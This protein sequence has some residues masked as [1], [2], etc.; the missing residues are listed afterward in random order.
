MGKPENKSI[1]RRQL[2]KSGAA[3]AAA[4]VAL[5][6][7]PAVASKNSKITG[8]NDDIL[9]GVIGTGNMGRANMMGFANEENVRV[10][11]VCD[12]Y[13]KNMDRALEKLEEE[14]KPAPQTFSD[15]RKLLEMKELDI[16]VVATPDHWHPLMS[17]M[18]C[19]AGKDVYVEKPISV[20]VSEG[21]KMV[22]VGRETKRV[23]GVGTQQRSGEHFQRAVEIVQSG[24]LGRITRVE[25]WNYG[26]EYPEG[27]GNPP[28]SEPPE[29]LDWDMWLGP[30]P[31]RP[32]NK[33]RF[34]VD[35]KGYWSTFRWFWDYAGGWMT[36]WGTH[37]IDVVQWA[38]ETN[39]PEYVSASGGK[40]AILDNRE[41]PDTMLA[42]FEYPDFICTY[43][44]R[45]C[46]R[47][48]KD[49]RGYGILFH[50]TD[51]SLFVDRQGY[52]LAPEMERLGD[53]SHAKTLPVSS[54]ESDQHQPHIKA[55][56]ECVKSRKRF[57]SDIEI[58]HYA[59]ATPH[60]ANI[61][62]RLGRRL[63]YDLENERFIGDDQANSMLAREYRAPWK[64]V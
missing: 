12:C 30:A 36:D 41:T 17:V 26:N 32:F 18:A 16:V 35:V 23:V 48:T 44:Y 13:K 43:E 45:G 25:T 51:A 64:L 21:R 56:I 54:G 49:G 42:I 3:L 38:M 61:S 4:A 58:G 22:E 2:L 50:G 5:E 24:R 55:F 28:D 29:G 39:G 9:V 31:K 15:F 27:F 46:S 33:N 62:L 63:K 10:A 47:E 34:G 7:T 6:G 11:A 59:S 40:Y 1:P 60:L 37:L 20:T 8:S 19:R 14:E 52:S 53:E 57:V